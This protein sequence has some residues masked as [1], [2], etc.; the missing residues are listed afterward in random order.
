MVASA[1]SLWKKTVIDFIKE[2][3]LDL[4]KFSALLKSFV[5]RSPMDEGQKNEVLFNLCRGSCDPKEYSKFNPSLIPD[6]THEDLIEHSSHDYGKCLLAKVISDYFEMNVAKF[7]NLAARR[8][9]LINIAELMGVLH[10]RTENEILSTISRFEPELIQSIMS[11]YESLVKSRWLPGV[12]LKAKLRESKDEYFDFINKMETLTDVNKDNLERF[13]EEKELHSFYD[14]WYTESEDTPYWG[15]SNYPILNVLNIQPQYVFFDALRRGVLAR[16]AARIFQHQVLSKIPWIY[17]QS[18]YCAYRI[19]QEDVSRDLWIFAR[20]GLRCESKEFDG[21]GFYT[22]RESIVGEEFLK[23][24]FTRVNN[25]GKYRSYINAEE[26]QAILDTL[27]LKPR[28]VKLLDNEV[29]ILDI[30]TKKP[31]ASLTSL[32]QKIGFTTP[33]TRRIL[34]QLNTKTNLWFSVLVDTESLGLSSHFLLLKVIP[35]KEKLVAD[36]FWE[37]PYCT[38]IHKIFGPMNMCIQFE[39]PIEAEDYLQQYLNQ[40]RRR[41]L[42]ENYA[43]CKVRDQHYN[44]NLRYYDV[45]KDGW[46]VRW[47]EWGLWIKEFLFERGWYYVLYEGAKRKKVS[48]S[49]VKLDKLDLQIINELIINSRTSY[50]EIGRDLGVTGVYVSQKTRNLLN[51]GVITPIIGSYRI[52]LDEVAFLAIDCDE[53]T[54]KA[55]T[56]ALNE[57]PIWQG[58]TVTGNLEGL[59]AMV[60]TPTG[61]IG[62]LFHILDS[63][64]VQTGVAKKCWLHMVGKWVSRRR[65]LRW[66]PIE[67]YSER[68]GWLFEGEQYLEDMKKSLDS[69]NLKL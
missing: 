2:T 15:V 23:E 51:Q 32:S 48:K 37:I 40:L 18:D 66:L 44:M 38:K 24:V 65:M 68:K 30:L 7:K 36:L 26:Y 52:G 47:D 41:Y 16:E 59:I 67:L 57:L 21:F 46:N 35:G 33:T 3:P 63:Y 20:H 1:T 10:A 17:E 39:I 27:A 13:N 4:L 61:D 42:V 58:V 12:E 55:L 34:E 31:K 28:P 43:L 19:L 8:K 11:S 6:L 53:D 5:E 69:M 50:T 22:R 56:V 60:F 64:I 14:P 25:I 49:R 9:F 29:K 45:E 54:V 62:Q